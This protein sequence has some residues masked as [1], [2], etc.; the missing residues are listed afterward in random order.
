MFD[1][2]A[3]EDLAREAGIAQPNTL[4]Q[5]LSRLHARLTRAVGDELLPAR[6]VERVDDA[7]RVRAATDE[8]ERALERADVKVRQIHHLLGCERVRTG[9]RRMIDW[10]MVALELQAIGIGMLGSRAAHAIWT[11]FVL[12][13][14]PAARAVAE[15]DPRPQRPRR[16]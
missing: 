11:D 13:L 4:A 8:F 5:R 3:L 14:S 16:L 6:R 2:E 7:P 12:S 9:A 10:E 15:P 1:G